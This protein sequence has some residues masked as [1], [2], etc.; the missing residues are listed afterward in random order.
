MEVLEIIMFWI[1]SISQDKYFIFLSYRKHRHIHTHACTHARTDT[2]LETRRGI[3]G[4]GISEK[5]QWD[6][7][8]Q[9]G[10]GLTMSK[11]VTY[12]LSHYPS[13]DPD[14][15]SSPTLIH[16]Q[17][18]CPHLCLPSPHPPQCPSSQYDNN[19]IKTSDEV[20]LPL[21]KDLQ[22]LCKTT[23]VGF[24]HLAPACALGSLCFSP[25]DLSF[26]IFLFLLLYK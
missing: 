6:Q 17:S 11:L 9:W 5:S 13:L 19:G 1:I 14:T 8:G 18:I 12:F 20:I 2:W 10:A 24:S 16:C 22:W 26:F 4:K 7:R 3:M 15:H 23:S 25:I 21:L